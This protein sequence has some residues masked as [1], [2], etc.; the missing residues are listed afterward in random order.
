MKHSAHPARYA[1]LALL[2]ILALA[3]LFGCGPK[4]P[5]PEETESYAPWTTDPTLDPWDPFTT[6]EG[7]TET[8][9]ETETEEP[10]LPVIVTTRT[11]TTT[12]RTTTTTRTTTKPPTTKPPTT[13]TKPPTTTTRPPTTY[14]TAPTPT[15]TQ[16]ATTTTTTTKPPTTTTTTT[17]APIKVTGVVFTGVSSVPLKVGQSHK[18]TWGVTPSNATNKG[19]VFRS[20]DRAVATVNPEGVVTAVSEGT[21]IITITT[22]DPLADRNYE[23]TITVTVSAVYAT[24]INISA[25]SI[26]VKKGGTLQLKADVLPSNVSTPGVTWTSADPLMATVSPT[27]LVTGILEGPVTIRATAKDGSGVFQDTTITVTAS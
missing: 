3:L 15:G 23:D 26:T 2:P 20:S 13:T 25:P 12:R 16:G 18:L 21:A 19:V 10:T 7:D 11:T 5:P 1:A 27:G 6:T 8:E 24:S 4:P 14:T 17:T 22:T 9:T